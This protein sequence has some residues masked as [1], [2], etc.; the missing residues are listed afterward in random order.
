MGHNREPVFERGGGDLQIR[1]VMAER[2]VQLPPAAGRCQIEGENPVA[3][4][5]EDLIEPLR[6]QRSKIPVLILLQSNS[7]LDLADADNADKEIKSP[8]A[9][10]PGFEVGMAP[11][12]GQRRKNVGIDQEHQKSTSRGV[13]LGRSNSTSPRGIASSI[14]AK[15]GASSCCNLR[16]RSYSPAATTTTAALPCLVTVCG[17]RRAAST[18]SL[19]RFLASCTDQV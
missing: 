14:S 7:A 1:A 11:P 6:Q 4:C 12:F 2:C 16:R 8:L 3:I 13:A 17:L 10:D 19:K 15:L 5:I 18:T 9:L